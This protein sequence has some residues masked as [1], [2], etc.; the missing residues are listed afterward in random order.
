MSIYCFLDD[1][2]HNLE[3][4]LELDQGSI[5]KCICLWE[6]KDKQTALITAKMENEYIQ[7]NRRFQIEL[8]NA[9]K[10]V[11]YTKIDG[12][13]FL[14]FRKCDSTNTSILHVI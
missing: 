11:I 9:L 6:W 14:S 13:K 12:M 2:Y 3:S 10:P 7:K 1:T 8:W 5:D 4:C